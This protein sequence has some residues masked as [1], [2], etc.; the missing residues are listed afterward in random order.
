MQEI[1]RLESQIETIKQEKQVIISEHQEL[2]KRL[3]YDKKKFSQ[4][5]SILNNEPN[6]ASWIDW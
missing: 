4:I 3:D 6:I 5:G 1:Q 2:T